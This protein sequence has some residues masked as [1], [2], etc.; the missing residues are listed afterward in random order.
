MPSDGSIDE[1][2]STVQAERVKLSD[3]TGQLSNAALTGFFQQAT[4]L[5]DEAEAFLGSHALTASPDEKA[6]WIRHAEVRLVLA[7]K[8]RRFIQKLIALGNGP[9]A[10]TIGT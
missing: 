4:L 3:L 5:L 7:G 2:R 1:I 8:T 9:S 10:R 6:M